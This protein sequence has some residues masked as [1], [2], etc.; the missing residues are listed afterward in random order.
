[1]SLQFLSAF[2]NH[3]VKQALRSATSAIIAAA[4]E[5]ASAAQLALMDEQFNKAGLAVAAAKRKNDAAQAAFQTAREL[6]R[7]RLTAAEDL[8]AQVTAG[9]ESKVE[10]RDKLLGIIERAQPEMIR[11]KSE[12]EETAR[13][14]AELTESYRELG[15]RIKSANGAL[16]EAERNLA[17]AQRERERS[18]QRADAAAVAAGLHASNDSMNVAIE[19]MNRMAAEHHDA[20]EAAKM[21][22]STL[23]PQDHEK[24]DPVIAEAMAKASGAPAKPQSAAERLA[25]LKSAA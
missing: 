19:A 23:A 8:Q 17:R 21:K 1:M 13:D 24:N 4:P 20:A 2:A 12:A 6:R 16:S 10:H 7:Q 18:E 11:L 14:F 15:E 5:G 22:A 25:A 3:G 9:D